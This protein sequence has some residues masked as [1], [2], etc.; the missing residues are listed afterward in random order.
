MTDDIFPL[1][2][3]FFVA[4]ITYHTLCL[5]ASSQR[6]PP[7]LFAFLFLFCHYYSCCYHISIKSLFPLSYTFATRGLPTQVAVRVCDGGDNDDDDRTNA[8]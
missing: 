6:D 7:P 5:E 8:T 3:L 4:F 1:F 2:A